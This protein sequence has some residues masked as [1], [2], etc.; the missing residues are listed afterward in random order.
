[1]VIILC[2]LHPSRFDSI[3]ECITVIFNGTRK[4]IEDEKYVTIMAE[5]RERKEK[6][7]I[8]SQQEATVI[9]TTISNES[10]HQLTII[11]TVFFWCQIVLSQRMVPT[12]KGVDNR[13]A[14]LAPCCTRFGYLPSHSYIPAHI[15]MYA[16]R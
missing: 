10:L 3:F 11:I 13:G 5:W 7:A 15:H 12:T 16:I 2:Q 14:E 8:F 9:T 6:N 1:M 4:S